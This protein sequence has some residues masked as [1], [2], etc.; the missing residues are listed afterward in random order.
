M[1]STATPRT[2]LAAITLLV[3]VGVVLW[4]WFAWRDRLPAEIAAHWS[5]LGNADGSAPAT[6]VFTVILIIVAGIAVAGIVV[7]L[8]PMIAQRTKRAILI[9]AG[10]AAGLATS[11]WLIPA[12]LTLQAGSA[13]EAVLGFWIVGLVVPLAYGYVP[14]AIAPLGTVD[15]RDSGH[16]IALA[17]GETGAWSRS[18]VST[19]F[20][21]ATV[22]VVLIA[23]ASTMAVL[24][25]GQPA[26]AAFLL[27]VLV[28]AVILVASFISIR[29]TVDWRG[30]RVVSALFGIPL[31]RIRL[32]QI[33]DVETAN[34]VPL[35]WGGWGYRII[36]GRSALILR[37]GPGMIVT[38][39]GQKQFAITLAD[40]EV[41]AALLTTLR[42]DSRRGAPTKP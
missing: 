38:T 11:V 31:K 34:L 4:S 30:L 15:S 24:S 14:Y 33:Q 25:S 21:W 37:R 10:M 26:D 9:W 12:W 17:S 2:V 19:I 5:G 6:G 1:S 16:R 18:I 29:V 28:L 8:L 23:A 22:A 7:S 36:P 27:I 41:P 32:D 42:G 35:E 3:P 13:H 40:P 20:I 39:T